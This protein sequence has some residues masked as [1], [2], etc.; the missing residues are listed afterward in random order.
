VGS[1]SLNILLMNQPTTA[2]TTTLLWLFYFI[3]FL[4]CWILCLVILKNVSMTLISLI[5]LFMFK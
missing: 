2:T 5:Y 3:V 4:T 1:Y